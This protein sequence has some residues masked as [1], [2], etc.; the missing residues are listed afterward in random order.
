MGALVQTILRVGALADAHPEIAEM[1]C[2]PVMVL[3]SGVKVVDVRVRV[4]TS[5]P[6]T[7]FAS[8]ASTELYPSD[9]ERAA[10]VARPGQCQMALSAPSRVDEHRDDTEPEV[11]MSA[12]DTL[13][14]DATRNPLPGLCRQLEGEFGDVL[15]KERIDDAAELALDELGGARIR[16]FVPVFAWRHARARL[17]RRVSGSV[18][19]IARP[20]R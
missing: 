14:T 11:A 20:K 4:R 19:P 6:T 5:P 10:P 17:R 18:A 8:R 15:S 16:E 9:A 3:P 1:D 7:P 13:M 12:H 2:N